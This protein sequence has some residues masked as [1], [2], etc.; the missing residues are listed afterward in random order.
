MEKAASFPCNDYS[1][2]KEIPEVM[3]EIAN[4]TSYYFNII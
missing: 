2:V 3:A 1:K 4:G